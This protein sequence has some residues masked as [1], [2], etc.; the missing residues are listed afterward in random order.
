VKPDPRALAAAL[1]AAAAAAQTGERPTAPTLAAPAAARPATLHDA[2]LVEVLDLDVARAASLYARVAADDRPGHLEGLLATARLLELARLQAA[3]RRPVDVE[4]LPAPLRKDF[5]AAQAPLDAAAL[6]ARVAGDPA[7]ALQTLASENG[8]LPPLR[9][10][11]PTAESWLLDQIGPSVRDR[12]REN[13]QAMANRSRSEGWPRFPDRINS[14][15]VLRMELDGHRDKADLRRALYFADWRAPA[16]IGEPAAILQRVRA[17]LDAWRSERETSRQHRELLTSLG[18][19][20]DRVAA[21]DP[22]AAIAL[23]Q[24]LPYYGDRLLH[25]PPPEGR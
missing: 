14:T 1:L 16:A 7:A 8:R 18:E 25:G 20:L 23:L 22:A 9:P 6:L 10:A 21:E 13:A 19:A 5:A 2:W 11:V 12:V 3:P 4:A 15:H 24:R 17:N